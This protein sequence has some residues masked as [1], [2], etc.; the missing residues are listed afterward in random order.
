MTDAGDY[1]LTI[2]QSP[3]RARLAG[4]K[5]KGRVASVSLR[6]LFQIG[7]ANADDAGIIPSLERKPVDPPPIIQLR[8]RDECDPTQ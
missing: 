1:E 3:I 2:R 5:E 8:V 7:H 6:V 4:G